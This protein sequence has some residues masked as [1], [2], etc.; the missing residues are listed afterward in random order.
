MTDGTGGCSFLAGTIQSCMTQVLGNASQ[1]RAGSVDEELVHQLRTGLVDLRTVLNDLGADRFGADPAW[2]PVLRG[3]SL[4]LGAHRDREVVLPSVLA[5]LFKRGC[6][7]LQHAALAPACR[8]P[9][10]VVRDPSLQQTFLSILAF[11]RGPLDPSEANSLDRSD[12][13][14]L[15][16]RRLDRLHRAVARDVKRFRKL[17]PA[18]QH[19]VRKRLSR[20]LFIGSAARTLFEPRNVERYLACATK[21]RDLLGKGHDLYTTAQALRSGAIQGPGARFAEGWIS[22]SRRTSAKRC[23]RA[24][25][26]A[27]NQTVF[28]K[29]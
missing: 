19:L 24:L 28:W 23:Q 17:E 8:A 2:L 26:K 4:E 20:L 22:K 16:A 29:Q 15:V 10:E 14:S 6:L 3:A 25:R 11:L 18:R 12:A 7:P 27:M 5:E 13:R 21:A 1:I 9:S